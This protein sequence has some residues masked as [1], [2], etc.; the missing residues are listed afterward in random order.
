[1]TAKDGS[2]SELPDDHERFAYDDAA[3]VLGG[4][5]AADRS[6]YEDHLARCPRCRESVAELGGLPS[7]LARVEPAQLEVEPPPDTLLPRLLAEA[8]RQRVR[9]SWRTAA[10]G[11]AAACVLALLVGGGIE[12]YSAA[13]R[14]PAF[15]LQAVGPNPG[16]VTATV[17]LLGSGR[18]TRIQLDCG[19][20]S[21]R[22]YPAGAA[23]SYRMVVYNRLGMM[24][25]LGSWTPQPGEDVQIVRNSPWSRPALSKI[26]IANE[27]GVVL[28]SL[29]L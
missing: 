23:P 19:Y 4:L 24:R 17:K 21:S 9:R 7:L 14:P 12:W 29:T 27:R 1:V 25:D 2:L 28:L 10:I 3:Y 13:H 6:A 5:S 18:Q 16:G 15:T 11:F 26:E 8:G 22:N 20:E